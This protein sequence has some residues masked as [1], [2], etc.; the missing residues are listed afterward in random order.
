MINI[1]ILLP[2]RGRPLLL[3]RLLKSIAETASDP[4]S[5]EVVLFLDEDDKASQEIECGQLRVVRVVRP[6][7]SAMGALFR[8]CYIES[9][10]RYLMLMNDDAVFST[11]GWDTAVAKTFKD[12]TD[13]IALIYGD[14]LDQGKRSPTFPILSRRCCEVMGGVAPAGY[15]SL[16]IESHI[17]DI[18]KQL[19]SLGH[20]RIRYLEDIRFEHLHYSDPKSR[21]DESYLKKNTIADGRLFLE[22]DDERA[23]VARK[24]SRHI[25]GAVRSPQGTGRE[26]DSNGGAFSTAPAVSVVLPVFRDT[27]EVTFRAL[28]A[29]LAAKDAKPRFEI[30]LVSTVS[31]GLLPSYELDDHERVRVIHATDET[32]EVKALNCG[33]LASKGDYIVFINDRVV[34][35]PGL[36]SALV[37]TAETFPDTGIVGCKQVDASNGRIHHAGICIYNDAGRLRMTNIYRGVPADNPQ[38]NYSREFDFVSGACMLVS[39]AAFLEAGGFDETLDTL[40]DLDL[41]YKVRKLGKKVIYTPKAEVGFYAGMGRGKDKKHINDLLG[42]GLRWIKE[43]K[44]NIDGYLN[45]DGF[46]LCNTG[47]SPFRYEIR[48]VFQERFIKSLAGEK[49]AT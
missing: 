26:R 4:A 16:H 5:V 41:C 46:C 14:D 44:C 45:E 25:E 18:F 29:L 8:E 33:A 1:S 43:V 11:R 38:V 17:F 6:H 7:G 39:K 21:N 37:W 23:Y 10:G 13:E 19:R 35:K 30:I 2:T 49:V 24:L 28:D 36:L 42:A 12:F 27:I 9:A 22:L 3:E 40:F 34:L 15:Q 20:D 48:P 47:S 31:R 32:G